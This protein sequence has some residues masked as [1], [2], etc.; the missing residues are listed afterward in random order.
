MQCPACNARIGDSD[1]ECSSCGLRLD[2]AESEQDAPPLCETPFGYSLRVDE[3]AQAEDEERIQFALTE[4]REQQGALR[5]MHFWNILVTASRVVIYQAD[6]GDAF[7]WAGMIGVMVAHLR[8]KA[9]AKQLA[10][11]TV[12]EATREQDPVFVFE[13]KAGR[14]KLE[15]GGTPG[16]RL[17]LRLYGRWRVYRIILPVES[18]ERLR[19]MC[20]EVVLEP[21][22]EDWRRK[23]AGYTGLPL[24]GMGGICLAYFTSEAQ[25]M[26]ETALPPVFLAGLAALLGGAYLAAWSVRTDSL[27]PHRRKALGL[28]LLAFG[29]MG[30]PGSLFVLGPILAQQTILLPA[31]WQSLR[32]AS[33]AL[34]LV[35]AVVLIRLGISARRR[36]EREREERRKRQPG[37]QSVPAPVF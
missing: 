28:A 24:V 30:L 17:V 13:R 12:G 32:V 1:E 18:A 15:C 36:G 31:G 5:S 3:G 14:I 10:G 29:L 6:S 16:Q 20:P 19:A 27:D 11:K 25:N 26:T 22:A 4:L 37:Q 34:C 2:R 21:E 8:R 33:V 7:F 23:A 9:K 35:V